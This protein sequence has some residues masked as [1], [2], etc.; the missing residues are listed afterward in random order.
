MSH[1]ENAK[2]NHR[3]IPFLTHRMTVIKKTENTQYW[4]GCKVTSTLTHLQWEFKIIHPFQTTVWQRAKKFNVHT[5]RA[6]NST[7]GER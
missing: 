5:H 4:R 3:E 2:P 1:Q 7:L 6:S